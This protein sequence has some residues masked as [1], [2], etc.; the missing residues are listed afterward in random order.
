MHLPTPNP[1]F[2][3]TAEPWGHGLVCTPL[4]SS[5]QH[6]FTTRQL[7][8]RPA[9]SAGS[10][11]S[12]W[13]QA[14]ASLKAGPDQLMRISQVHGHTVRVVRRGERSLGDQQARPEADAIVAN[15]PDLV[16][17]VQVADCVPM[18]IA[19]RRTGVAGAVH[20]GWRGTC[21]GIAP[22]AVA[23][24]AR[25]FGTE[26]GSLIVAMGPSIGACCYDVG[27]ELLDAF[28]TAGATDDQL[29]RWFVRAP[30]GSLR[31]DLWTVNS[32]QLVAAGV[33]A[34]HIH[35]SGLCTQTHVDVFESYRAEGAAAGR[36]AALIRVPH[37]S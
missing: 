2:R 3:W 27:A 20:A 29:D 35:V 23:T 13:T 9:T 1:V 25:E 32:D 36:M 4:Q 21:A 17:A 6:L 8:L 28:R 11:S 30:T 15:E 14:T 34:D 37:G 19:D 16:L 12:A 18:L 10:H 33:A 31:L 22:A 5:A 7:Q 26:P 24:L